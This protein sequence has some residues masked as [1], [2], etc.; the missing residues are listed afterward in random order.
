[1]M[2]GGKGVL[3]VRV[4]TQVDRHGTARVVA[5]D[6]KIITGGNIVSNNRHGALGNLVA[7][8]DPDRGV[9]VS[10]TGSHPTGSGRIRVLHH[11]DTGAEFA[12][13]SVPQWTAVL[14]LALKAAALFMPI[15]TV[16]WDVAITQE[17]VRLLEGN[18]WYD[19]PT[20]TYTEGVLMSR[21]ARLA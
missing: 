1:M 15:R 11:P 8:I 9:L 14:D 13:I 17:G 21:M 7:D 10:C 2:S 5:S 6:L 16:G 18:I 20:Q 19:P 12:G 3:S 4:I